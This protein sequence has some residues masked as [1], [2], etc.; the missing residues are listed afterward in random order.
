MNSIWGICLSVL[1]MFSSGT[2]EQKALFED[3]SKVLEWEVVKLHSSGEITME[4]NGVDNSMLDSLYGDYDWLFEETLLESTVIQY[5]IDAYLDS[6]NNEAYVKG[7]FT[8]EKQKVPIEIYLK[9]GWAYINKALLVYE[10]PEGAFGQAPEEYIAY[11]FDLNQF[12]DKEVFDLE[13]YKPLTDLV[14]LELPLTKVK[15]TYTFE[16]DYKEL[17][18]FF[19]KAANKVISNAEALAKAYIKMEYEDLTIE[20]YDDQVDDYVEKTYDSVD[21]FY[22]AEVKTELE[23]SISYIKEKYM[24]E[25]ISCFIK[26]ALCGSEVTIKTTITEDKL[27][28]KIDSRLNFLNSYFV[29]AKLQTS[30][31]KVIRQEVEIPKKVTSIDNKY[32]YGYVRSS[33]YSVIDGLAEDTIREVAYERYAFADGKTYYIPWYSYDY[34][35]SREGLLGRN[36]LY[37]DD[38][39][40][41]CWFVAEE[42]V[43]NEAYEKALYE[44][45][46]LLEEGDLVDEKE[47]YEAPKRL[48]YIIDP[49]KTI[50]LKVIPKDGF[51]LIPI[52]EIEKAGFICEIKETKGQK[53]L[54]ISENMFD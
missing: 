47:F 31:E 6:S 32:N 53:Q 52:S 3:L 29:N 8:V 38:E 45:Y 9:D 2:P 11:P 27:T 37:Y 15:D 21:A 39:T 13:D 42:N 46:A 22:N 36:L 54:I 24:I 50:Y 30:I 16:M 49:S 19:E 26:G 40:K 4:E 18:D 33:E 12:I 28:N 23:K 17:G 34:P 25:R 44:S 48:D 43:D 5:E 20:Q 14:Q 10:Y 35:S 7:Y 51:C 41:K 1:L